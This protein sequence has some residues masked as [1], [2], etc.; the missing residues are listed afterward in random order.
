MLARSGNM[1]AVIATWTLP[2]RSGQRPVTVT[3]ELTWHK[4]PV[5][6]RG[7]ALL[8]ILAVAFL[9]FLAFASRRLSGPALR[10]QRSS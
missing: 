8:A 9:A 3:G 10:D 4:T 6:I 1:P 5:P 7:L 2:R